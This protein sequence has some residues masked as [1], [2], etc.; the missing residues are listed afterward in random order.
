MQSIAVILVVDSGLLLAVLG[1]IGK[2]LIDWGEMRARLT[3]LQDSVNDLRRRVL[4][5]ESKVMEG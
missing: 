1:G 2:M 3:G 4:Q 5:L